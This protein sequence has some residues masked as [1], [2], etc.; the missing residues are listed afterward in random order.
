MKLT[1]TKSLLVVA[2]ALVLG[3]AAYA[4]EVNLRAK[5]PFAFTLGDKLYPAGEYAVQTVMANTDS[6]YIKNEAQANPA[7]LLTNQNTSF[8]PSKQ[9][10]LVF[11]RVGKTYFLYQVWVAGSTVGREFPKGRRE[12]ELAL[13]G[14]KTE[15]VIVAAN[16]AH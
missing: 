10:K 12:M 2:A 9:S 16:I 5:I 7:L 14:T 6:L 15:T 4:Q 3:S 8:E 1:I 11:H 13:N